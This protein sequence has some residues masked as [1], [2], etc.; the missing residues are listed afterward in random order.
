M[1]IYVEF[2][3]DRLRLKT[4]EEE[5]EI[6]VRPDF[7]SPIPGTESFY[8]FHDNATN[9][10]LKDFIGRQRSNLRLFDKVKYLFLRNRVLAVIDKKVQTGDYRT[11]LFICDFVFGQQDNFHH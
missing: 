9:N 1:N 5:I 6:K 2:K 11:N 7:Y 3:R 4:G 10:R 8:M